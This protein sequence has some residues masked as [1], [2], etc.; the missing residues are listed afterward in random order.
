[1]TKKFES[2]SN[3][4]DERTINQLRCHLRWIRPARFRFGSRTDVLNQLPHV[5]S[6]ALPAVET[7]G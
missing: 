4:Y 1:M 5:R 3:N 2:R 6:T 7:P